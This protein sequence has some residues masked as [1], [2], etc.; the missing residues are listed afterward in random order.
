MARVSEQI[1]IQTTMRIDRARSSLA[2][3]A[4]RVAERCRVWRPFPEQ[5]AHLLCLEDVPGDVAPRIHS[6]FAIALLRSPA[7]VMVESSRGLAADRNQVLL[8]PR[9]QLCAVRAQGNLGP[10]LLT[11]LLDASDLE[12]LAVPDRPALV[13]DQE[14]VGQLAALIGQL[15]R[16]VGLLGRQAIPRSLL[17][18]LFA[19]SAPLEHAR[20]CGR[21]LAPVRRHLHAHLG[22]LI[23]TAALAEMIGL[24]E[25]H[26]IRAFHLEFG[27]PPHAYHL[28]L[29]LARAVEL[30]SYGLSVATVANACGFAD[31]SHLSR[32]F[33]EVYGLTPGAWRTAVG[34]ARGGSDER[35]PVPEGVLELLPA[36][37][38]HQRQVLLQ[39]V[40]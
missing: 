32:K 12:R 13:T 37:T 20:S 29:R 10:G 27:L 30:L 8:T 35:R 31:Q 33:K 17:E 24:T 16:P 36:D 1:T 5:V 7:F 21:S 19:R 2:P 3:D 38:D 39:K 28:R 18:H 34:L 14:C 11:L 6:Q 4:P 15:Q 22:E 40:C 9:L 23:P 25:S 26:F